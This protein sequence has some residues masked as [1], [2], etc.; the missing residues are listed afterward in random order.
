MTNISALLENSNLDKFCGSTFWN[1][2]LTWNTNDPQFTPCFEKTVLSWIPCLFIWTFSPMNL[3]YQK[4]SP[5]KSIPWNWKNF[6][7]LLVNALVCAVCLSDFI[8][9]AGGDVLVKVDIFMP[10]LKLISCALA[11]V[12]A[13]RNKVY[14]VQSSGVLFIF[15]FLCCIC[16]IP[17]FRTEIRQVQSEAALEHHYEYVSY[18]IY[19]PLV[20]AMLLLNCF[21]EGEPNIYPYGNVSKPSPEPKSGFLNRI[22]LCF[23]DP[24]MYK[25]WRNPL[26]MND[27]SGDLNKSTSEQPITS[28]MPV[29]WSCVW[30]SFIF[31]ASLRLISDVV[32][33]ANPKILGLIISFAA[34]DEP[35]WK[36]ILYAFT[37]FLVAALMTFTNTAQFGRFF[38][39]GQ[40]V[41]TILTSAIYRK[42]LRISNSA[43]KNKTVG[44]IVN[45]MSNDAQKF[46]ELVMFV[47][48]LWSAPISI[49]LAIYFLYQEL[50]VAQMKNKDERVKMMN[51]ILSGMKVLKLYAWEES[52]EQQ[53]RNIR[54]KEVNTLKKSAYLN[55]CSQFIWNCAP[56][57]VS[58]L[59]FATYVLIDEKNVLTPS[60]AFVSLALLNLL[61]MPMSMLP[62]VINQLVQTWVS[63]NRI[64]SFLNAQDLEPYVTHHESS[65]GPITV[66]NGTFTW[67][68]EPTLR[69][70]N[71]K[72]AKNSL[73]A[74]VGAVGAGKSS[75]ISALLG[76]M[77]KISGSVNSWGSMAYVPQQAWIQNATV[78]DNITFG[79]PFDKIKYDKVIEAC[80]LKPDF[81]MLDYGDQTEIGEKG[82]NL[83]GGQKQRIS[84]ARA[85]Y[86][87][88]D[89]YLL[90]DPLSAVDSHV[91][92]HIFDQLIGKHY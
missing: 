56:F 68:E 8:S 14:G 66:E 83:S 90:D 19:Y 25:G 78:R 79:K 6:A 71:M 24:F 46:Q 43:R 11:L 54:N 63:V 70:I 75:L 31:G 17:Q 76:E 3:Y 77:D 32:Q 34:S 7:K 12:L 37:M 40:H 16:G 29:L 20:V 36:G 44:E 22:T 52:F 58:C 35:L 15:W 84:L 23:F 48:M 38:V 13:Y 50:G 74:V 73:T 87:D 9:S 18:M 89:V 81:K 69:N 72:V 85:V 27:L 42:A 59:T 65:V 51:E 60:K 61:R 4:T 82:I 80:A 49:V 39:L 47:N 45:L 67:G 2:T 55:A 53:I 28:V 10:L 21:G 33:F 91:G 64:N 88:A 26:E 57:M 62:N 92:K 41:K 5:N 86:A 1:T 30:R